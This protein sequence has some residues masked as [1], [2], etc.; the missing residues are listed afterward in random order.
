[1]RTAQARYA[2]LI[3]PAIDQLAAAM[4]ETRKRR[5][6]RGQDHPGSER[7]KN[8]KPKVE[9]L[10]DTHLKK[11][12]TDELVLLEAITRK[13]SGK[14]VPQLLVACEQVRELARTL[15]RSHE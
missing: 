15:S 1:M 12:S 11:L 7:L 13:A 4:V 8:V 10:N 2:H 9:V 5:A 3:D 14:R 6:G